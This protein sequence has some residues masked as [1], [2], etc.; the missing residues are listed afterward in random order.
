[1]RELARTVAACGRAAGHAAATVRSAPRLGSTS[2]VAAALGCFQEA[3]STALA[4]VG[5]DA[6]ICARKVTAAADSWVVLDQRAA[7]ASGG[8]RLLPSAS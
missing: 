6:S 7:E 1:M 2:E 3:L 4:V 5:D 8:S